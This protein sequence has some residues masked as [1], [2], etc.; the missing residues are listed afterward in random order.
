MDEGDFLYEAVKNSVE[1]GA[2]SVVVTVYRGPRGARLR[3]ADDGPGP[4]EGLDPFLKGSSTKGPGRGEG[5]SLLKEAHPEA[6]MNAADGRTVL[7][8]DSPGCGPELGKCAPYFLQLC[9]ANGVG[10]RVEVKGDGA[11]ASVSLEELGDLA[12][13]LGLAE[14]RRLLGALDPGKCREEK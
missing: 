7:E 6:V 13:G 8:W 4:A 1:A 5:L 9:R 3:V 14:A 10:A 12:T 2:S 11:A